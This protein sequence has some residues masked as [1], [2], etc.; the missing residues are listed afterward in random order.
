VQGSLRWA[1]DGH[2][3]E[4]TLL[5]AYDLCKR[6]HPMD[7][8]P[9]GID[10]LSARNGDDGV[11]PLSVETYRPVPLVTAQPFQQFHRRDYG[12]AAAQ[13]G[14][15]ACWPKT[16]RRRLRL[17]G[18]NVGDREFQ[19][20][21]CSLQEPH[22]LQCYVPVTAADMQLSMVALARRLSI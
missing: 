5:A 11:H 13:W 16:L 12:N 1:G 21:A 17:A 14:R 3:F 6:F 7:I 15:H 19:V 8:A 10:D 2:Q 4:R 22:P 20:L 18:R 9:S